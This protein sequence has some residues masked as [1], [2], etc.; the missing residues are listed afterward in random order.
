MTNISSILNFKR[1]Y[2]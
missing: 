1:Y 2:W